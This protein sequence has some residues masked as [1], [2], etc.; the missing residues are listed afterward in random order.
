MSS[1]I[2]GQ[3]TD[4]P[5]LKNNKTV[6]NKIA[7]FSLHIIIAV[8]LFTVFVAGFFF[9]VASRIE[10]IAVESNTSRV[11]SELMSDINNT[12]N[13]S[14]KDLIQNA[15]N[16][17]LV[18]P[19]MSKEDKDVEDKNRNLVINTF[20]VLGS[21]FAGCV[22][23]VVAIWGLMKMRA[24]PSGEKG[25]HYPDIKHI[26]LENLIL[27]GFVAAVEFLFMLTIGAHYQSIDSNHIRRNAMQTIIDFTE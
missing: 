16:E 24:G 13:D 7:E 19:D 8:T 1:T 20:I 17:H 26:I 5:L 2:P 25:I 12:L 10:V 14:E 4:F 11:I 18:L 27:L 3:G 6:G 21:I 15:L 22:V 9:L 23:V